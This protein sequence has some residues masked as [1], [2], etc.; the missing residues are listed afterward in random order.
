MRAHDVRPESEPSSHVSPRR[1]PRTEDTQIAGPGA[2][3]SSESVL[4]LQRLAGNRSVSAMLDDARA[5]PTAQERAQAVGGPQPAP[6]AVQRQGDGSATVT[7]TEGASI[8]GSATDLGPSIAGGNVN[9]F[10][11]DQVFRLTEALRSLQQAWLGGLG[12]FAD[13]QLFAST[14]E[15]EPKYGEA[16]LKYAFK[17]VMKEVVGK[18]GEAVPGFPKVYEITFGLI[19]E[20]DKEHERIEKAQAQVDMKGFISGYR[21]DVTDSFNGRI[22]KA[23][24]SKSE[25]LQ[26]FQTIISQAP[27]EAGAADLAKP[28]VTTGQE[29]AIAG[30]GAEYLNEL[31]KNVGAFEAAVPKEVACL[32]AISEAWVGESAGAVASKGG[33]EIYVNGRIYLAV[34]VRIGADGAA[35]V[36]APTSAKLAAP[37][38]NKVADALMEAM[39]KQGHTINDLSIE[40]A[41]TINIEVES[42]HWY[43]SNDRYQ[44]AV[45]YVEAESPIEVGA[46]IPVSGTDFDPHTSGAVGTTAYQ[47]A[48]SRAIL[49]VTKLEPL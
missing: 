13:H 43:S 42:G 22:T 8:M 20:L 49:G 9:A 30:P 7:F 17:T 28:G 47:A 44:L 48:M 37:S 6:P 1:P 21:Q 4:Q 27:P 19:E 45:R 26:G 31:K 11:G 46:A 25:L 3:A 10:I 34:D 32:Q 39:T 12:D 2:A 14:S 18:L 15:A 38:A 33:G 41:L 29:L 35:T 16:V 24:N 23:A 5:A 36:A 40:K